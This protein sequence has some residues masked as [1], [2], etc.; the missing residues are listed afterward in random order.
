MEPCWR[1]T[2]QNSQSA[3]PTIHRLPGFFRT[4]SPKDDDAIDDFLASDFL[5]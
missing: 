5:L 3:Y 1:T 4:G 2:R